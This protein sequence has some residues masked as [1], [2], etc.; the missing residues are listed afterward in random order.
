MSTAAVAPTIPPN[1]QGHPIGFWFFFWGE[2]AE[3]CSYYGMRAILAKYMT[4][5]LGVDE[6]DAGLFMSI[7]IAACYFFPLVGGYLADNYFGK[8]WTIVGFSIPYVVA[9]FLVGFENQYVVFFALSLLAMGSGVIKP[10]I[11][12]LMGLTYDQQRPGQNQLRTSAFSWFYMA[13]NI[14]AALSQ[15]AMPWLRNK[16]GYQVAFLFPAA[17]MTVALIIFALGKRFYAKETI[18]PATTDP[19]A[20]AA[21]RKLKFATLKSIGSLFL[22]VMFFWA[23]FD[24]SASTW[25]F[26]ADT[27]MDSTLFGLRDDGTTLLLSPAATESVTGAGASVINAFTGLFGGKPVGSTQSFGMSADAIQ[28]FN[29]L[30]IIM[31]VPISVWFFKFMARRGREVK[32]TRKLLVGFI[33]TASTMFIMAYAGT[34]GGTKQTVVKITTAN[35]EF[36]FPAA[37]SPM[38]D[39]AAPDGKADLKIGA[40]TL[41]IEGWSYDAKKKKATISG[42]RGALPEGKILVLKEG[43]VD[44]AKSQIADGDRLQLPGALSAAFTPGEYASGADKV[45]VSGANKFEAKVGEPVKPTSSEEAKEPAKTTVENIE[46][47]APAERVT[48]WWQV[49]AFLIITIAEILISVTGLELA[50][51]AAP[52][53]MKSFVTAMWLVTVFLANILVNAPI[54]KFLWPIMEPPAYFAMLG[55]AMLVV[56]VILV[57]VAQRFDRTMARNAATTG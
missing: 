13:I 23:I 26:F 29:P 39:I 37:Q 46:W 32:A 9:Q 40:T 14:G 7:F 55:A 20:K 54:T 52:P 21:E 5:S 41:A 27:Y 51:V 3:R 8:Y 19:V 30:F 49:F 42:M 48:V 34:L 31:G 38:K 36:L 53:T 33:L 12:T 44:F 11:S 2:F 1:P 56:T 18:A 6:G 57:P 50:F 4:S 35:G 10:N 24:Q 22:L 45:V 47:V 16:Y 28:G 15:F 43:G 25:I 17:L